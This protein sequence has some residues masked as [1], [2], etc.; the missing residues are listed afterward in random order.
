MDG[1]I[2]DY[3]CWGK[4]VLLY[5]GLIACYSVSIAPSLTAEHTVNTR[6]ISNNLY[7]NHHVISNNS[8]VLQS[9]QHTNSNLLL[10]LEALYIKYKR[11]HLN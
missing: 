9:L 6:N 2:V 5:T 4:H 10:F 8:K 1:A 7:D 11:P 3:F